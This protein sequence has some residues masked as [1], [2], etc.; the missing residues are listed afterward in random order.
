MRVA[1]Q[2]AH[3]L[4]H[5]GAVT[6]EPNKPF[7]WASGIEAPIYT[8][9]RRIIAF[10]VERTF[11]A[12]SLADLIKRRYPEATVVGGVATAGIPHAALVAERLNL[13]MIYVRGKAKDHGTNSQIEGKL[14]ATD[15]VVLIDDLIST[16]G[17][18]LDA[19]KVVQAA[20]A[21]VVG[22]AAI[23]SYELPD[24]L[25]NF[26]NANIRLHTL[27]TY[28]DLIET[29]NAEGDMSDAEL[30]LVRTWKDDPWGYGKNLTQLKVASN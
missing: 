27:T 28:T 18:V 19:A 7:V 15:K 1:T 21:E 17:S 20:G 29:A 5:I 2:V 14:E 3:D 24:S 13:P 26:N 30:A 23:F 8:D 11:I 16:G 6:L 25:T 10:P 12:N 4:L 22:V 9:N